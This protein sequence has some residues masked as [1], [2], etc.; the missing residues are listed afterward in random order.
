[1]EQLLAE[2]AMQI[3]PERTISDSLATLRARDLDQR[4]SDIDRLLPLADTTQ[5]DVLIAEKLEITKEL[6]GAGQKHYK[7]FRQRRSG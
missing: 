7:A 5:K 3:D 4:L 1:V 6:K 2:D